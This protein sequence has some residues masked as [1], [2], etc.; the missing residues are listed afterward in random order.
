M[1]KNEGA[2]GQ[3]VK[4]GQAQD[5]NSS[6]DGPSRKID[7]KNIRSLTCNAMMAYASNMPILNPFAHPL[8]ATRSLNTD[9]APS[10]LAIPVIFYQL[11]GH[12]HSGIPILFP[13]EPRPIPSQPRPIP[14]LS[15]AK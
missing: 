1:N 7:G 13:S 15:P 12:L 6:F 14:V 5:Y 10:V 11:P 9:L 2:G 3:L 4:Y 8:T